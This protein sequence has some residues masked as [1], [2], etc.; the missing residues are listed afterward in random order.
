MSHIHF[1]TNAILGKQLNILDST[2]EKIIKVNMIN[3]PVV[4]MGE[5]DGTM[6]LNHTVLKGFI[7]IF[8]NSLAKKY[9]YLKNDWLAKKAVSKLLHQ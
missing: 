1:G 8:F 7:N 4:T 5:R 9:G 3:G 6:D 2:P